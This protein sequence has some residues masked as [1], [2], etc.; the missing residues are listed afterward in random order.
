MVNQRYQ[1]PVEQPV[2]KPE[3]P[4]Q[5]FLL[6][7]INLIKANGSNGYIRYIFFHNEL[8]KCIVFHLYEMTP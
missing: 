7:D 1:A 6:I 8:Y 2:A 5:I 3:I 4:R